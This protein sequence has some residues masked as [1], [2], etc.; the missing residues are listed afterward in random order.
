MFPKKDKI[1]LTIIWLDKKTKKIPKKEI[2]KLL[3]QCSSVQIDIILDSIYLLEDNMLIGYDD[4]DVYVM[5]IGK[6]ETKIMKINKNEL[7][8]MYKWIKN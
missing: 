2:F 6:E 1:L 4:N 7:N 3:T 8:I 5:S